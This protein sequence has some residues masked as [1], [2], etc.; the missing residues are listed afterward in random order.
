MPPVAAM[1]DWMLGQ[2]LAAVGSVTA[3]IGLLFM[4]ESADLEVGLPLFRR[5][6]WCIGF[7]FLLFNGLFLDPMV[8]ALAPL[9]LIAPL[10]GLTM[11]MSCFLACAF[12]KE[13]LTAYDVSCI[14]VVLSGVT[15]VSL[16]GPHPQSEPPLSQM[17]VFAEN[18]RFVGFA[19]LSLCAVA[20]N[21][22]LMHWPRLARYRPAPTSFS[23]TVFAAFAAASCGGLTQV[24]LKI[25][26]T[27]VRSAIEAGTGA[28]LLTP[29][30]PIA[31]AG[32]VSCAPL[33][34]YLLNATLSSSP[35]KYAVPV[36]QA[37]LILLSTAAGGLFFVE[38]KSSSAAQMLGFSCG[39][40][41]AIAGIAALSMRAGGRGGGGRTP[42]GASDADDGGGH[43]DGRT[44]SPS[45]VMAD[46]AK[47]KSGHAER[48]GSENGAKAEPRA[49]L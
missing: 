47:Q 15:A 2:C 6:R 1:P 22:A 32:L 25:V 46:G 33:Q 24:S 40:A 18:P 5:W 14:A 9:S 44:E 23:W 28:P 21:L 49:L 4:K 7:G 39:V 31:L 35:V 8:F 41:V 37:L 36:Y 3:S 27:G 48:K 16:F 43:A 10:A 42:V 13:A 38:F 17:A 12:R 26:A 29:V 20:I 45:T 34:L 19:A 11:V 30:V